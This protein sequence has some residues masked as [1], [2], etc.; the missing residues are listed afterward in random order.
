MVAAEA[1]TLTEAGY[2]LNRSTTVLNK[3]VDTGVIRARQRRVGSAVQRLLG[4]AE[5]R[6]LLV[7]DRLE[8]D[9]TPAGR[10]RLYEAIR[11]L[12]ADV[13][14]VSLGELVLDLGKV[15]ADLQGRLRRLEEHRLWVKAD[16]GGDPLIS[17]T[18]IPVHMVAALARTQPVEEIVADFPS[19]IPKQVASAIEYAK[20]Y[21]R[22]GRPYPARSLKRA[23]AELADLGAFDEDAPAAEIA[24]RRI[25]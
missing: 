20:A 13:H 17:G 10:R 11:Q 15:D 4:P 21:P 3:A 8:K 1:L 5:M 16:D 7:A 24:P 6:F 2:V 14:R 25:P 22:R 12:S 9:L 19:L 23:L 18:T